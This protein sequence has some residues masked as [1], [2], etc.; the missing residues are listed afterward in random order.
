M[1]GSGDSFIVSEA[2]FVNASSGRLFLRLA[3]NRFGAATFHVRLLDDGGVERGGSNVSA[4]RAFVLNVTYVNQP[5]VFSIPGNVSVVQDSGYYS[6]AFVN[7]TNSGSPDESQVV[8]LSVVVLN[9]YIVGGNNVAN[10]FEAGKT[11]D[12]DDASGNLTFTLANDYFGDLLV[13]VDAVDDG[14]TDNGGVD[15][16]SSPEFWI[17]IRFSNV[18]PSITLS[19]AT[20]EAEQ[21][22]GFQE[23]TG[24]VVVG[25]KGGPNEPNQTVSFEVAFVEGDDDLF[26]A[27]ALNQPFVDGSGALSFGLA[28]NRFGSANFTV[29]ARDSLGSA[30]GGRDTSDPLLFS[31]TIV[32][33]NQPPQF[34]LPST[35]ATVQE[36]SS[37]IIS[38]SGAVKKARPA[39]VK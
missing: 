17:R 12:I 27:G 33:A 3:R 28:D 7:L 31:I 20:V 39:P 29:T 22:S 37:A 23:I 24:F 10:L 11:P 35:I 5:P 18:A 36:G 38:G 13:R 2:P 26:A 19:T 6:E 14:G 32:F 21:N 25:S 4:V 9:T 15:S 16:F 34:D 8:S 30:N 1:F